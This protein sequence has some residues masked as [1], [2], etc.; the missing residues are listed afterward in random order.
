MSTIAGDDDR[1]NTVLAVAFVIATLAHA[2]FAFGTHVERRAVTPPPV[3]TE[4]ELARPDPPPEPPKP[5]EEKAP[6]PDAPVAPAA[7]TT[8]AA[9]APAAARAGALL[10]A[11]E[12]DKPVPA[13]DAPVDFV[14]D[15]NGTSYGGGVVA[16]GGTADFGVAGA[17]ANGT[18][19]TPAPAAPAAPVGPRG[20]AVT[21]ASNL[22]RAARLSEPDA[23]RGFYP[24]SATAD[25]ATATIA[26]VVRPGGEVLSASV[27]SESPAGQGFGAAARTCLS[28][29]RFSPALDK[30]G[31]A[32]TA[33]TTVRVRFSR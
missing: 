29:K 28:G 31:T 11:K 13:A 2:A 20:D 12:P 3:V 16:K 21:P 8:A 30:E 33:A 25:E 24:G 5:P 19:T 10:T 26:V 14:T 22:S 23:C 32:V 7:R 1:G 15:P 17:K 9:P 18:G 6:E 27:I 4:I